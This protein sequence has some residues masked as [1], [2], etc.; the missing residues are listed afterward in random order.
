[1]R[2]A[3]PNKRGFISPQLNQFTRYSIF[4]AQP[5]SARFTH[6]S[7]VQACKNFCETALTLHKLG[8]NVTL[9]NRIGRRAQEKFLQNK[10]NVVEGY[11]GAISRAVEK[12]LSNHA[13]YRNHNIQ[14]K[15]G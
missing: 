4:Q 14:A 10:I 2:I 5:G 9:V 6:V 12:Y 3:V 1:M 8:V 15:S 13:K 7:D 11:Q